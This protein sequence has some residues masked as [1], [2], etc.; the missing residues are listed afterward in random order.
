MIWQ[1]KK[2]TVAGN[3]VYKETDSIHFVE[4]SLKSHPLWVTPK[5]EENIQKF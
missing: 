3:R 4:S 5:G 1:R 2:L